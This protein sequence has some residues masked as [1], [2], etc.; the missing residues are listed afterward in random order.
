MYHMKPPMTRKRIRLGR[1]TESR[2]FEEL[3]CSVL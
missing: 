3:G 2:M 1:M